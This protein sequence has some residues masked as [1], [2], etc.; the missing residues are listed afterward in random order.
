LFE[1]NYLKI[2]ECWGLIEC[3]GVLPLSMGL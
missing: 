1:K 2:K 3:L